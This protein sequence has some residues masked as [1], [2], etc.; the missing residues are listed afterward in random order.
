MKSMTWIDFVRATEPQLIVEPD[1]EPAPPPKRPWGQRM[2][3]G[4]KPRNVERLEKKARV[5]SN[6]L[7][8]VRLHSYAVP[9]VP[10]FKLVEAG[11]D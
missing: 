9:K 3:R 6:S 11:S 2:R 8:S 5:V 7:A 4:N 1:P 10:K